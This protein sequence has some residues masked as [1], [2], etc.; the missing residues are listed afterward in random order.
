MFGIRPD[1]NGLPVSP[2]EYMPFANAEISLKVKISV[3][4]LRY[5]NIGSGKRT[6]TVNGE[7]TDRAL[8]LSNDRLIKT[9]D[10]V[11]TD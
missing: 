11:V 10:V 5:E 2:S 9:L 7:K 3:I 6:F 1:L 4:R 8:Y